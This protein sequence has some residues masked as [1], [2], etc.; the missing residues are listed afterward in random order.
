MKSPIILALLGFLSQ[1]IYSLF[2]F[3]IPLKKLAGGYV[4]GPQDKDFFASVAILLLVFLIYILAFRV[5]SRDKNKST[6]IIIFWAIIFSLSMF[7]I[8]PIASGDIFAYINL[9]RVHAVYGQNPYLIPYNTLE[10]DIFRNVFQNPWLSQAT[11]YG[12]AF[13]LLSGFFARIAGD[14]LLINIFLFKGLFTIVHIITIFL[15]KKLTNSKEAVFLYAWNPLIIFEISVNAH[16]DGLIVFLILLSILIIRKSHTF[17]NS[18]TAWSL[19]VASILT[20]IYSLV[21]V[22]VFYFY[23]MSK[24]KKLKGKILLTL[25]LAGL[26]ILMF[27]IFY[28]PFWQNGEIFGSY[29]NLIKLNHII[30]SPAILLATSVFYT[31]GFKNYFYLGKLLGKLSFSVVFL[32][33]L[34][35]DKFLMDASYN[36]FLGLLMVVLGIFLLTSMDWFVPWYMT[37]FLAI[38]SVYLETTGNFSKKYYIYIPTLYG[39]LNYLFLR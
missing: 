23:L 3:I 10:S 22:P 35:K 37:S 2:F 19:L 5:I 15:V 4:Y 13:L 38:S 28:T 30:V 26:T 8:I 31:L 29:I 24:V 11:P 20:K 39:I 34:I 12:P 36:R 6:R 32:Y 25:F 1:I 7:F 33:L 18:L 27:V 17:F 9:G 21:L 16:N 14:R